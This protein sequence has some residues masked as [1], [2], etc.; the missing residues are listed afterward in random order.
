MGAP[1][2]KMNA[3]ST[4]PLLLVFALFHVNCS[5][6][7]LPAH[8]QSEDVS[9]NFKIG[10]F[11]SITSRNSVADNDFEV[12][13]LTPWFDQSPGYIYWNIEDYFSPAEVDSPVPRPAVGTKY[14]RA[15]RNANLRSGL[16][17]LR[18]PVITAYPGD[19]VSFDYW[20][21]SKRPEGNNLE[22]RHYR[23]MVLTI[24]EK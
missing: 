8:T 16:A 9:K 5:D 14:L 24:S 6:P 17:I 7:L 10:L 1:R 20:I 3:I 15:V 12:G 11:D 4:F 21:R 19:R 23:K 13:P 22:V 2:T 18:S